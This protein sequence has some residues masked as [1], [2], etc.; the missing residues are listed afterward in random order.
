MAKVV[1]ALQGGGGEVTEAR[2]GGLGAN[3]FSVW[4]RCPSISW[5]WGL[6]GEGDFLVNQQS[7]PGQPVPFTFVHPKLCLNF[8]YSVAQ[9]TRISCH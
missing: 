7:A 3:C 9:W 8:I 5:G 6:G 2:G 4:E 1:M